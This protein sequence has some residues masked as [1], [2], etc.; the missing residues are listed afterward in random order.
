MV[1]EALGPE[2]A[3]VISDD[4]VQRVDDIVEGISLE[5]WACAGCAVKEV[6]EIVDRFRAL[7]L[8][9]DD[10]IDPKPVERVFI[11][12]IGAAAP[13]VPGLR[14]EIKLRSGVGGVLQVAPR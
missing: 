7:A 12:E 3:P 2:A 1:G 5:C 9:A 10:D 6:A 11:V 13:G 4:L 8:L 14:S